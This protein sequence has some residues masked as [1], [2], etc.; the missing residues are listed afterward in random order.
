MAARNVTISS[1]SPLVSGRQVRASLW[2]RRLPRGRAR[3][4]PLSEQ[5]AAVA[6]LSMAGLRFGVVSESVGEGRA[7]LD[8]ARQVED[9]EI[10]VLLLRDHFSAGAF[11]Q[12]LAPFTGLAAAAAVTTRLRVGTIVLSNNFRHPAIVAH[13][14]ASLHLISGGRSSSASGPAGTSPNTTRPGSPSKPPGSAAY[15]ASPGTQVGT[16]EYPYWGRC[17][18]WAL[19]PGY[20]RIR[21]GKETQMGSRTRRYQVP[22]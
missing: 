19:L 3:G 21:S 12:Q 22:I 2:R 16:Q 14:A 10:D 8:F 17:I 20:L 11:G 9:S 7:W 5:P 13:E 4:C 15:T 18:A 6:C 1:C